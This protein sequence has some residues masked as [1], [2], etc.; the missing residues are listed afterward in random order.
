MI[1]SIIILLTKNMPV[2]YFATQKD[3]FCFHVLFNLKCTYLYNYIK[4]GC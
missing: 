4:H 1:K 3:K 2:K